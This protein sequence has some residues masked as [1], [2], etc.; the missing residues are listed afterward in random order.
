MNVI[1]DRHRQYRHTDPTASLELTNGSIVIVISRVNCDV[2]VQ[3]APR[4]MP[5]DRSDWSVACL[6]HMQHTNYRRAVVP[7]ILDCLMLLSGR[8]SRCLSLAQRVHPFNC[9]PQM[10]IQSSSYSNNGL[11]F[12]LESEKLVPLILCPKRGLARQVPIL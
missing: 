2:S 9:K 4:E 1:T 5:A 3:Y 8:S 10:Q 6:A 7:P 12:H 11:G